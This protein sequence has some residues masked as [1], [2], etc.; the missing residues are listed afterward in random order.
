MK[1]RIKPS[2]SAAL[3]RIA[4]SGDLQ[5]R[6]E[7]ARVIAFLRILEEKLASNPAYWNVAPSASG[8]LTSYATLSNGTPIWR[9]CPSHV[10]CICLLA[11]RDADLHVLDICSASE[12]SAT[13]NGHTGLPT[14]A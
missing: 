8:I 1:L 2:A 5:A 4:K 13:E 9:L 10:H 12:L 11:M 7:V 14:E 3:I 6:S